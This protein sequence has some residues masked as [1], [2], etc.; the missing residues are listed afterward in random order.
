MIHIDYKHNNTDYR[1]YLPFN[2]VPFIVIIPPVLSVIRK[3]LL[4]K[5]SDVSKTGQIV[6]ISTPNATPVPLHVDA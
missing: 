5:S 6:P 1:T 4:Q 2:Y 3:Y